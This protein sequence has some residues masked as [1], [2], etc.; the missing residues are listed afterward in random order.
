[1][2]SSHSFSPRPT[3]NNGPVLRTSPLPTFTASVPLVSA[4]AAQRPTSVGSP[5]PF[6]SSSEL[7]TGSP[8]SGGTGSGTGISTLFAVLIGLLAAAAIRSSKLLIAPTAWRSA[9]VVSLIERPG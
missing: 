6:G 3:R 5:S 4:P 1:V 2:T 7:P 8:A 9:A